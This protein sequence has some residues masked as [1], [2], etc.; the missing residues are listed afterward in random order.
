MYGAVS[1]K[2][3]GNDLPLIQMNHMIDLGNFDALTDNGQQ[4]NTHR[5]LE[6]IEQQKRAVEV[7]L[8]R[9][10]DNHNNSNSNSPQNRGMGGTQNYFNSQ[11][12]PNDGASAPQFHLI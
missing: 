5:L 12:G 10:K 3:S 6:A 8:A 1:Y 2:N 7:E 11:G 4:G 9:L